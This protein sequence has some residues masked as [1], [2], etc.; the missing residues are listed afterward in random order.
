MNFIQIF[1]IHKYTMGARIGSF[2][3]HCNYLNCSSFNQMYL[4]LVG[5][6]DKLSAHFVS[7]TMCI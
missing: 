2:S 4:H 5:P 7:H 3:I 1:M 6:Q